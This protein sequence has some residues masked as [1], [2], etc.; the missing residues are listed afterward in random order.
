MS[1]AK[2]ESGSDDKPKG[3]GGLRS[4]VLYP[5]TYVWLV[6]V[7]AMD[8]IMTRI[9]LAF[10]GSEVNPIALLAIEG[11]GLWGLIVFKFVIIALVIILCEI[12]GR[13]K[14]RTGKRLSIFGVVVSAMPGA[15]AFVLLLTHDPL[16][17]DQPN[18]E[19]RTRVIESVVGGHS[20]MR[21]AADP[22]MG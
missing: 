3:K 16:P 15:W 13:H 4:Q 19:A 7:S 18:P 5:N 1:D 2:K 17:V 14:Y 12:I 22:G 6:F 20:L 11:G 9:V 8:I 21:D 10:G